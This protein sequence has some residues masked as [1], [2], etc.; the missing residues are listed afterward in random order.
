MHG[1]SGPGDA[2]QPAAS[3]PLASALGLQCEIPADSD[4]ASIEHALQGPPLAAIAVV[5]VVC[6]YVPCSADHQLGKASC[7]LA[8]R[9]ALARGPGLLWC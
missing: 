4:I 7:S 3:Q 6:M 5:A 1:D 8:T 9:Y 2:A